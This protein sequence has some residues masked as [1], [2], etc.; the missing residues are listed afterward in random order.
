MRLYTKVTDGSYIEH[1]ESA[2]AWHYDEADLDFGSC[3]AKELL[4]HLESVLANEPVVVNRG[5]HIVEVNHQGISKGVVVES[6]LSSMVRG[7]KAPDFVL[8]I[9]DERSDEDMFESIVCPAIHVQF[10]YVSL[11]FL[12]A[13][14]VSAVQPPLILSAFAFAACSG[15][16]HHGLRQGGRARALAQGKQL[17]VTMAKGLPPLP[18]APF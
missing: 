9:G 11:P 14:V 10:L 3:Q 12:S 4:D 7:G 2:L 1:K 5:Q 17:E 18:T 13:S 8:C 15:T 16:S 6:L